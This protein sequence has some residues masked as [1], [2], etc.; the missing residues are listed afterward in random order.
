MNRLLS[1]ST[2]LLDVFGTWLL[3]FG[4]EEAVTVSRQPIGELDQFCLQSRDL[5][6]IQIGLS[7]DLWHVGCTRLV[8]APEG[9]VKSHT[10]HSADE[11][12]TI[13]ISWTF[14]LP[15]FVLAR[16]PEFAHLETTR[17]YHSQ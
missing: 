16:L 1:R 8:T 14:A 11:F 2:S 4:A 9:E 5:F 17:Q 7:C 6:C 10:E 13:A 3:V 15:V 12:T